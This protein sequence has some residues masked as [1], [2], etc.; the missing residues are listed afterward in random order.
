MAFVRP[1][2]QVAAVIVLSFAFSVPTY[3]L[4]VRLIPN[5]TSI[6]F[7]E[8]SGGAAPTAYTFPV[9]SPQLTTRL[10]DPLGAGNSDFGGAPTEY[11]D[12]FYS[13]ADGTFNPN[14]EYLTIEGVFLQAL[15]QGGGLNLAEIGLNFSSAPTE[16][17]NFVASFVALGNNA[18]PGDVGNAIDNNLQT[19]TTMGNTIGQ[20][21]RLRVTL[22]FQS[23]SGTPPG[24]SSPT[25]EIPTLSQ[26]A[27]MLLAGAVVAV[28][29][30][31]RGRRVSG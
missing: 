11:Y 31:L 26:W 18:I 29:W 10:F 6:T 7:Y 28:A 8:R 2:V 16:F 12:V 5:L 23:S 17:G 22:G 19:H 4:A 9:A 24:P 1:L 20:T 15:P 13:D 25:A 30:L 3:A 21:Q 27:M 14:G